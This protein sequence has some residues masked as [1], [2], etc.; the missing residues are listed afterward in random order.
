MQNNE[1]AVIIEQSGLEK[2]KAQSKKEEAARR[3]E[4]RLKMEADKRVNDEL[5]AKKE[6]EEK[7]AKAPI[8]KQLSTWIDTF[9]IGKPI[10]ENELS[11]EIEAKF[12][13]FKTWA[14]QLINI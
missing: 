8:K 9:Q 5:K 6:A 3:E 13:S 14:K 4:I 2:T 1:L 10:T 11:K 7:A 12:E